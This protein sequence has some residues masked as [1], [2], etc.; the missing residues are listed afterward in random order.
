METP[1]RRCI[2]NQCSCS[3]TAVG[4][5]GGRPRFCSGC[6]RQITPLCAPF[7]PQSNS[8]VMITDSR[9]ACIAAVPQNGRKEGPHSSM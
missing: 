8:C 7:P 2:P 9:N 5:A 6:L 4:V 1:E 3:T